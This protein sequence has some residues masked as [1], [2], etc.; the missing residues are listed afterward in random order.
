[1]PFCKGS[2]HLST[3]FVA[4]GLYQP[5]LRHRRATFKV[6]LFGLSTRRVFLATPITCG[7]VKLLPRLF[8]LT[9]CLFSLK[10]KHK[11]VSFSVALSVLQ[12][13]CLASLPVRKYDALR[14]SDFPLPFCV[15]TRKGSDKTVCLF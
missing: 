11:A 13:F 14:C 8:T 2:C 1:V 6:G 4:K 3:P 9:L 12:N 10:N 5:T 7:A 15:C